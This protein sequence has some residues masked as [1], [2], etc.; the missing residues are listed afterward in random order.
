V[1]QTV[2]KDLKA[3]TD[4]EGEASLR[5]HLKAEGSEESASQSYVPPDVKDDRA[6]KKALDQRGNAA[7]PPHLKAVP[8]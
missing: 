3:W 8:N 7:F 6:L 2:P 1:L 5:G 4:T